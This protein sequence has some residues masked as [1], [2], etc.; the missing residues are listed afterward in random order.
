MRSRTRSLH[1]E[2]LIFSFETCIGEGKE[3]REG[4]E[5]K[6]REREGER[7]GRDIE[8]RKKKKKGR[9]L[10]ICPSFPN[11]KIFKGR[12]YTGVEREG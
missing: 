7:K 8:K 1:Y 4:R 9:L 5:R 6:E 3:E 11:P 10:F 2:S 12:C